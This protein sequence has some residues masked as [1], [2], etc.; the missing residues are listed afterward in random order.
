MFTK[1][2]TTKWIE[3]N[4]FVISTTK[5]KGHDGWFSINHLFKVRGV[6]DQYGIL[7]GYNLIDKDG[8]T[9]YA[10]EE[11]VKKTKRSF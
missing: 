1:F 10:R 11:Q 6:D 7:S 9:C 5:I 2:I 8:N 3:K 4:S